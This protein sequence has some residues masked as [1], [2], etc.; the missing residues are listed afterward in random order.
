M[1]SAGLRPGASCKALV[2]ERIAMDGGRGIGLIAPIE[3]RIAAR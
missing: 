3:Q 2:G 1:G